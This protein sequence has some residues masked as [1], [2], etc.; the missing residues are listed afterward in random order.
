MSS[1]L[2]DGHEQCEPTPAP[3]AHH[4]PA[5]IQIAGNVACTPSVTSTEVHASDKPQPVSRPSRGI[6][7]RTGRNSASR[8]AQVRRTGF[9]QIEATYLLQILESRLSLCRE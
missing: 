3:P 6:S 4:G 7:K 5:P 2:R 1:V 8:S 9:S